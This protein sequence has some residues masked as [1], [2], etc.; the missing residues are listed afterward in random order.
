MKT[1]ILDTGYWIALFSPEKEKDKQDVVEYVSALID[2]NNYSVIIPFPTLYEFL[3]SKLSRKGKFNLESELSKQKYVKIYDNEY[4]EKALKNFTYQFSFTNKDISLVDE[5][6]KEMIDDDN[7]KT[8]I[9]V[10]FDESLKKYARAMN[11]E[12]VE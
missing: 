8:D 6:I 4:R 9:I 5:V 11:V 3:N 1:I 7:L 2:E 12:V 10:T